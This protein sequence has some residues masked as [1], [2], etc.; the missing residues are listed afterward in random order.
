EASPHPVLTGPVTQAAEN[1]GTDGVRAI[2]T[3]R[4]GEGGQLRLLH[5][6]AEAHTAGLTVDWAPWTSTGHLT[7]LPTYAFQ[8]RRHWLP[9]AKPVLDA[10]GLGLNPAG[11]PLL[12]AAVRLASQDGLVLTG[13]MSLTTHSWLADHGVF[14][15]V[16]LPGTAFV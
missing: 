16:I 3:L 11:H 6:L 10:A 14:G 15:T 5:S 1:T 12:G 8:H 9:A 4:R 13:Q 7:D 2:G